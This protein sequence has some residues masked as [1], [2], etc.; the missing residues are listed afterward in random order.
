M[1][2]DMSECAYNASGMCHTPAITVGP[3]AECA[4]FV[5]SS[6]KAG[7]KS[8]IAGIGACQAA[9]CAFNEKLEC[10]AAAVKVAG[11]DQHADCASFRAKA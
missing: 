5:H 4:T 3:H 9:S 7:F 10:T 1:N 2:C 8:S 11:H 6:P